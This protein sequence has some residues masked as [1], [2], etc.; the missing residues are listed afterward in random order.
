MNL[1]NNLKPPPYKSSLSAK[2][3]WGLFLL[4]KWICFIPCQSFMQITTTRSTSI[5]YWEMF[6]LEAL[7]FL[8]C[9][10]WADWL[11][12]VGDI[13]DCLVLKWFLF[14]GERIQDQMETFYKAN[15]SDACFRCGGKYQRTG[16]VLREQDMDTSALICSCAGCELCF[17]FWG[18]PVSHARV[19][20]WA[21]TEEL[22]MYI[23]PKCFPQGEDAFWHCSSR[24]RSKQL[25]PCTHLEPWQYF[26]SEQVSMAG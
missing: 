18:A 24:R 21:Q 12:W 17:L 19:K 8:N 14:T 7:W 1:V 4:R 9:W 25:M 2:L 23:Q 13:S 26:W 22:G 10:C 5:S 6:A 16:L 3:P 20:E 11:E 15:S